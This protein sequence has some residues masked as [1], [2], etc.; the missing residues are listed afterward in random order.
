MGKRV[1]YHSSSSKTFSKPKR[2]FTNAFLVSLFLHLLLVLLMLAYREDKPKTPMFEIK[3]SPVKNRIKKEEKKAIQKEIKKVIQE[4]KA[5]RTK[6]LKIKNNISKT[7]KSQTSKRKSFSEMADQDY[8]DIIKSNRSSKYQVKKGES[9]SSNTR[10]SESNSDS[11]SKNKSN[12]GKDKIQGIPDGNAKKGK[13]K[14]Q[15]KYKRF[16]IYFPTPNY[17]VYYRRKGIQ[18]DVTLEIEVN[19]AGKVVRVT[20]VYSSGHLKLDVEAKKAIRRAK[21]SRAGGVTKN[22]IGLVKIRFKLNQ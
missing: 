9:A 2:R 12:P 21:F 3:L 22:D 1:K 7:S 5:R 4:R 8:E 14:W 18:G 19:P 11:T 13:I 20:V 6:K 17:P 15:G 16:P 10:W